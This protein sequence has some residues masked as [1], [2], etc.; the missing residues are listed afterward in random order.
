MGVGH[1]EGGDHVL[2]FGLHTRQAFAAATL[3]PEFGERGAFDVATRSYGHDHIL[4][5]DQ[6]LV[7]HIGGPFDDLCAARNRKEF[8][9]FA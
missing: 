6:I 2:F 9:H 1:K 4:A 8:T 3:R 7:V 5:F